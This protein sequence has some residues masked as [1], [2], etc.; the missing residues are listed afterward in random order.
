VTELD[1]G[2]S[3]ASRLMWPSEMKTAIAIVERAHR[4]GAAPEGL[5][6]LQY[7]AGLAWIHFPEAAGGLGLDRRL[8]GDVDAVM[9]GLGVD[10]RV[11]LDIG[12]GMAAPT[13]ALHGSRELWDRYLKKIF[14]GRERW[15]QLFSEPGSGS[16]LAGLSTSA[17]RN[18]DE[19]VV[20]GQK[21]WTSNAHLADRGIL[22]ART[23]PGVPKHQ[24]LTYFVV[25]MRQ[26]GVT[27][28]PLRQ[29][30][31][32]AEF[33]E[34]FLDGVRVPD[35]D[36]I[37]DVGSGWRVAMT[38]LTNE[39]ISISSSP[40]SFGF[41]VM[42]FLLDGVRSGRMCLTTSQRDALMRLYTEQRVLEWSNRRFGSLPSEVAE[43][44]FGSLGKVAIAS[45]NQRLSSFAMNVIG[46]AAMTGFDYTRSAG[47]DQP[48]A[49]SQARNQFLR[50]RANSIEGG[51]SE[52]NRNVIAERILGLP[53]ETRMD[54]GIPWRD[55]PR[56]PLRKLEGDRS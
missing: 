51:T 34:V 1:V 41:D 56:N 4:A 3:S 46:A 45:L 15:C 23:D 50:S 36:R 5:R 31:G 19:W 32:S 17:T 53:Q 44:P 55:V 43:L 2:M 54:K 26:P 22:V 10:R 7:D 14:L 29:M 47:G 37:G 28:R 33:N 6:E 52:I 11:A 25:D 13:I 42:S 21:V 24:G 12:P 30:T 27:V 48:D 9:A 8:Q 35:R 16:D 38:T 49:D 18:D 20:S 40:R 39:R